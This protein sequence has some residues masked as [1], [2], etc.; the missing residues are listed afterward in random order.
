MVVPLA[1]V[2]DGFSNLDRDPSCL[3]GRFSHL[4]SGWLLTLLVAGSLDLSF[5]LVYPNS[6]A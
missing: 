4:D 2:T 6:T 1:C 5:L 3:V